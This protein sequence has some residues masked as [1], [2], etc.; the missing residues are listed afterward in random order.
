MFFNP[1][2]GVRLPP[3]EREALRNTARDAGIEVIDLDDGVDV[4]SIISEVVSIDATPDAF[5]RL[6]DGRNDLC[7]VLVSP[8]G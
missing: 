6:S 7:K 1:R 3:A 5:A 4:S 2:S 8:D